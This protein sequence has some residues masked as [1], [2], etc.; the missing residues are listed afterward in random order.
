M[1]RE[2]LVRHP[3]NDGLLFARGAALEKLGRLQE[4]ERSLGQAVVANPNNAMALN[5]LGYML[6][7]HGRRL[8]DSV[9]YVERAVALDPEN[10]A[11][12]DSLGYA[13]FKLGRTTP[14]EEMLRAAMRYDSFDP[15]IRDHLGDV[16]SATGR[17]G[18]A[19]AQ[20]QAALEYGHERPERIRAKLNR[21]RSAPVAE[22]AF[23]SPSSR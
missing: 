7:E 9:L 20:W 11:Y 2:G 15:A 23:S 4:A 5:Y 1:A 12:L 22:R 18:E 17:R 13:L 6:A 21:A 14:A 10:P 19:V 3:G 8:S 16:L